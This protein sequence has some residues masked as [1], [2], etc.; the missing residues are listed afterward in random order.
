[1][2]AEL[3]R[4]RFENEQLSN[5]LATFSSAE[6]KFDAR[7]VELESRLARLASSSV[8]SIDN[9]AVNREVKH[10][11]AQLRESQDKY[12]SLQRAAEEERR[13]HADEATARAMASSRPQVPAAIPAQRPPSP[14]PAAR[15]VTFESNMAKREAENL[16]ASALKAA[17]SQGTGTSVAA[18]TTAGSLA[19][20]PV[21]CGSWLKVYVYDFPDDLS[22]KKMTAKFK[23]DCLNTHKCDSQYGGENLL[24]QFS[25]ELILADFFMQSCV[26]T[27]DPEEAHL[28]YVPFFHDVEYRATNR[29]LR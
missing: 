5:R 11:R 25:L 4:L 19:G 14:R 15:S 6:G 21:G 8:P 3:S 10:L 20:S 24:A 2:H 29:S 26:R 27:M 16:A 1:M 22:W 18:S 12:D 23:R 13:R 17:D 7:V 28:F 9:A